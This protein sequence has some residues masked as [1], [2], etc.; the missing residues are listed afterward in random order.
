[1]TEGR[2]GTLA[3]TYC[4]VMEVL[5]SRV[6][7]S[8]NDFD[9]TRHWYLDAL[10]LR[11]YREYGVAGTVTGVVFFAGGGFIE[12]TSA[13]PRRPMGPVPVTL[14]L[15]VADVAAEHARLAARPD[16][17]VT[18]EPEEMPWGLVECWLEDP[19]GVRIVLVEV[20]DGHPLRSRLGL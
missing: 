16:V 1:M 17:V 4:Q 8:P 9:R 15:Q 18:A 5:S 11:V 10:G 3:G 20:P 19:D 2:S 13:A 7:L 6:L 12:V 14:W